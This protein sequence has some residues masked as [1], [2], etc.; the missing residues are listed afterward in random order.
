LPHGQA[1]AFVA[2]VV[3][4]EEVLEGLGRWYSVGSRQSYRKPKIPPS[5]AQGIPVSSGTG[6]VPPRQECLRTQAR[7]VLFTINR[8]GREAHNWSSKWQMFI[9]FTQSTSSTSRL[10][11]KS[12]T[13]TARA[14]LGATFRRMNGGRG[15]TTIVSATTV[16]N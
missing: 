9:R 11:S 14:L 10:A 12:T 2:S 16:P 8:V 4:W 13:I 15:P 5:Q 1:L 3:F 7:E 6:T